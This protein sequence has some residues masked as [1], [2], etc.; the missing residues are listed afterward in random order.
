MN[1][2]LLNYLGYTAEGEYVNKLSDSK[3]NFY[4]FNGQY[5][6]SMN[7]YDESLKDIFVD[8]GLKRSII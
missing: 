6:A 8:T 1:F 4:K 5:L 3:D 2:L 7:D